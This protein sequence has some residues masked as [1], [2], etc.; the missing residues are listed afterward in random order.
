MRVRV[1]STV[2]VEAGRAE[3]VDSMVPEEPTVT[4]GSRVRI[5]DDDGESEYELAS[6]LADPFG[7]ALSA[8]SPL[9]RALLGHHP[10]D[11]VRFSAPGGPMVVFVV[12][13]A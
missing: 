1:G 8:D 3:V 13:V 5:R 12:A 11:R 2:I 9:G 10:G 7:G 4:I 6:E